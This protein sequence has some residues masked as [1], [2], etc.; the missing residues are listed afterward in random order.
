MRISKDFEEGD[1]PLINER[2][3]YQGSN[4]RQHQ[5]QKPL[6]KSVAANPI[7]RSDH[8]RLRRIPSIPS[9]TLRRR[10]SKSSR[11]KNGSLKQQKAG[12]RDSPTLMADLINNLD[13]LKS[14]FLP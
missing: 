6:A 10:P 5:T 12:N 13:D 1:F 3:P 14:H 9:T 2:S 4:Q 11:I 8:F 7:V